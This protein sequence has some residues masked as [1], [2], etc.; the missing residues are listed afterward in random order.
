MDSELFDKGISLYL[1]L[2]FL[3]GDLSCGFMSLGHTNVEIC[4]TSCSE[5]IVQEVVI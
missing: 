5:Q 3:Y 1:V 2:I 4:N